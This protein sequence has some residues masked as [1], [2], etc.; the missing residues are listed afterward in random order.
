MTEGNVGHLHDGLLKELTELSAE[1]APRRFAICLLDVDHDDG[2]V[3]GWGLALDDQAVAYVPADG[4]GPPSLLC[5]SSLARLPKL[6]RR[7]GD[8]RLIWI[9]AQP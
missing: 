1:S 8:L 6:L 4:G 9:D 7:D 2:I 3:L 5:S